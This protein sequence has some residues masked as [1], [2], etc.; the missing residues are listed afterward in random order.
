MTKP[1]RQNLSFSVGARKVHA[2][3]LTQCLVDPHAVQLGNSPSHS[4]PLLALIADAVLYRDA[5]SIGLPPVTLLSEAVFMRD[6]MFSKHLSGFIKC[7]VGAPETDHDAL[8][9]VYCNTFAMSCVAQQPSPLVQVGLLDHLFWP[10]VTF[11]T[12]VQPRSPVHNCLQVLRS[13]APIPP[14]GLP[15]LKHD[16]HPFRC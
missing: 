8:Q 3:L 12:A 16:G 14:S 5:W 11:R 15:Q 9:L 7:K 10:C 4:S 6:Y 13:T 1:A 2:R